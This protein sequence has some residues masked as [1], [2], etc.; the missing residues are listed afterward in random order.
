MLYNKIIIFYEGGVFMGIYKFKKEDLYK[1]SAAQVYKMVKNGDVIK[2]FPNGFWTSPEALENARD[3]IRYLIE[4]EL[5]LSEEEILEQVSFKFFNKH[6]LNGMIDRCFK[7]SPY[8]ALNCAYPGKYKPWQLAKV[9]TSYWSNRD[10]RMQAIHWLISEKLNW[11]KEDIKEKL[12][13]DVFY[14]NGLGSLLNCYFNGNVYLAIE[15]AFK[16]EFYPWEFKFNVTPNNYWDSKENRVRAVRWLIYEKLKWSKD[17]IRENLNG[18]VFIDNGLQGLLSSYF[19]GNPYIAID[20][21]FKGEFYPWEF[22]F[23]LTP[24][25]YWKSKKNRVE[26]IHW[27]I[28]K[29]LKWSKDDVKKKLNV[30]IFLENGLY[31]LVKD[32][33][34]ESVD[35]AKRIA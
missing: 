31:G 3:C 34:H 10:N 13:S 16:D 27:L 15:F 12:C 17:D 9:S 4:E 22:K 30:N 8:E 5:Q 21:A 28:F 25:N 26:A 29:R 19:Q 24:N 23:K 14:E 33:Y 7:N 11:S 6:K 32:Y 35:Y 18:Q 2:R 20:C 1:L